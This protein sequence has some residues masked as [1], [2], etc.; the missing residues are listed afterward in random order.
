MTDII[1]RNSCRS[2]FKTL[3]TLDVLTHPREY[4]FSLMNL[5]VNNQEHS[6]TNSA[7][8]SVKTRNKYQ[9]HTPNVNFSYFQNA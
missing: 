4:I 7:I 1:T 3:Q 2:L 6:E 8:H 9:L 5:N